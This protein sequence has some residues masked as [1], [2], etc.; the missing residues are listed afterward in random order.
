MRSVS[1]QP[2]LPSA[3]AAAAGF[4]EHIARDAGELGGVFDME[5]PRVGRIEQVVVE[6][7]GELGELLLD[8]LE[9]RLLRPRQLGASEAEVAQLVG[10][11]ALPR[12]VERRER[13]R[14]G[15]RAITAEEPGVLREV[16]EERGDLRQVRVVRIAQRGRAHDRVQVLNRGPRAIQ[17]VERV[18]KR[19]GDV[20]P[21]RRARI[22]GDHVDRVARSVDEKVDCRSH[23]LGTYRV[24]ARQARKV[25]QRIG[26]VV[27]GHTGFGSIA[28]PTQ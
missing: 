11:R 3:A 4:G 5:C 7:C 21:A 2:S 15:E 25:E 22:G 13:R 20:V 16:R 27:V 9:P 14:L 26:V 19:L 24:E 17:P 1:F 28:R 6:L 10:D 23:V 12:G 8:R 18:G